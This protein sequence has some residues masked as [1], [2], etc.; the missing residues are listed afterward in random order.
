MFL[1]N[2]IE[3]TRKNKQTSDV[4]YMS[5]NGGSWD[6]P[7]KLAL[8]ENGVSLSAGDRAVFMNK[9]EVTAGTNLIKKDYTHNN[10]KEGYFCRAG[11]VL[12]HPAEFRYSSYW[13]RKQHYGYLNQPF[14]NSVV[15]WSAA[16]KNS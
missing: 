15:G 5:V 2:K 13:K 10:L 16:N 9:Q 8:K 3:S 11:Q 6:R 12:A 7:T 1:K 4:Y 14:I